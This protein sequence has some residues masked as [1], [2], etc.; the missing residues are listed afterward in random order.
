MS[1]SENTSEI[2]HITLYFA[3]KRHKNKKKTVGKPTVRK[4]YKEAGG[5]SINMLMQ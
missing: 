4:Q 5:T 1:P 2:Y 3:N